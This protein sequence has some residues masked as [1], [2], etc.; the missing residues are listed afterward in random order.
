[1][2]TIQT[3][4]QAMKLDKF[5][6]PMN[7]PV[8]RNVGRMPGAIFDRKYEIQT[9]RVRSS[10][11]SVQNFVQESDT[12]DAT[13]SFT[14]GQSLLVSTTLDPQNLNKSAVPLG[15]PQISI[16]EGTVVDDTMQIYPRSGSGIAVG[17]YRT[18]FGFDW[19]SADADGSNIVAMVAIDNVAAGAVNILAKVKWKYIADRDGTF[20]PA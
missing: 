9:N 19:G 5:L 14:T 15:I 13:G 8:A 1:M 7:S 11:V 12:D 16:Y 2:D 4:Q 6:R 17:D 3:V 18:S 10:S 20:V